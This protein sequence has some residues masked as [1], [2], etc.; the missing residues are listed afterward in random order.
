[1]KKLILPILHQLDGY[2][3]NIPKKEKFPTIRKKLEDYFSLKT[4]DEKLFLNPKNNYTFTESYKESQNGLIYCGGITTADSTKFLEDGKTLSRNFKQG[5]RVYSVRG[6]SPTLTANGG[7]LG[8]RTALIQF[9][10][11]DCSDM[12]SIRR[13]GRVEAEILQGFPSGY[14]NSVSK[15]QA[16][17]ML[18]NG[19]NVPTI[20]YLLS[21]ITLKGE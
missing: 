13:L 11:E 15:T 21:G 16:L 1:M 4:N 17:T 14:T 6:I 9:N 19:W 5:Y 18:G 2:G 3:T 8:G 20:K 7:G 10:K 12:N